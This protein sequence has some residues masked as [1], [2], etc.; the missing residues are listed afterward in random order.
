MRLMTAHRIL[1]ATAIAFFLFYASWEVAGI[2][3]GRG[4]MF[5]ALLSG[6]GAVALALYFRSLRG[7]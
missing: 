5:R 7:K 3:G 2:S 1:I 6:A 4:S